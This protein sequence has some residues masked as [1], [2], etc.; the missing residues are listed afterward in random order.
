M[1]SRETLDLRRLKQGF[2]GLQTLSVGNLLLK[3]L[4]VVVDEGCGK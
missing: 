4:V 2:E 3:K 1:D